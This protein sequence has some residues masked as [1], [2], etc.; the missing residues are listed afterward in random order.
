MPRA[1]QGTSYRSTP[2]ASLGDVERVRAIWCKKT[3]YW[4][5]PCDRFL[6]PSFLNVRNPSSPPANPRRPRAWHGN[7]YPVTGFLTLNTW[8]AAADTSWGTQ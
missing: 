1:H 8:P 5:M 3:R 4:V 7:D 6:P 2:H